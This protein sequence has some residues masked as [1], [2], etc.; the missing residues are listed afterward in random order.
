MSRITRKDVIYIANLAR[1]ALSEEEIEQFTEQ[2]GKILEY[3]EKLSSADTSAAGIYSNRVSLNNVW[4]EDLAV[5]SLQ[6]EDILSNAPESE[7]GFFKV[8]KVIE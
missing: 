3:M 6:A 1:L 7:A 5:A 8:N 4:R 2:I